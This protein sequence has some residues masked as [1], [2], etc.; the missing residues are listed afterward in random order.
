[1]DDFGVKYVGKEHADH[2]IQTLQT[3]YTITQDWSRDTYLGMH[4][5]WHYDEN[6]VDISMPGY[7]EKARQRLE[8][9]PPKK[10]QFS[11]HEAP[12]PQYGSRSQ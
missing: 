5:D 12:I 10:P 9:P 3:H 1:V 7:V 6:F 2:L 4:L 11:P 8:Y